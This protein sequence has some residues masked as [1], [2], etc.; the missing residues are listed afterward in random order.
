MTTTSIR[1]HQG[2]YGA[3]FL[4]AHQSVRNSVSGFIVGK[5][6]ESVVCILGLKKP[7]IQIKPRC[8]DKYFEKGFCS[9][10]GWRLQDFRGSRKANWS[11]TMSFLPANALLVQIILSLYILGSLCET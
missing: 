5:V 11:P 8:E 3:R 9:R 2:E 6:G 1:R 4:I 7:S 10:A